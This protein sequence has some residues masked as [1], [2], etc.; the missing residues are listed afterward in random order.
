M[1]VQK[2]CVVRSVLVAAAALAWGVAHAQQGDDHGD[3]RLSSTR[4]TYGVST[5]GN[6]ASA[7]DVDMFRLDLEGRASL[8]MFA[9]GGLDT[10]GVLYDSEGTVLAE[11]DDNGSGMNFRI[12]MTVDGGVY[13][14]SVASMM[15]VGDYKITARIDRGGDA[16]G[17]T[18]GA[19]TVLPL[20]TRATG[21]ID[22]ASDVDAFRIEL[23]ASA[24][25]RISTGG[26]GDTT[27][28]LRDNTDRELVTATMGGANRNFQINRCMD[29]GIYYL[30]VSA[31][32]VAAYNVTAR[33]TARDHACSH[34]DDDDDD[35]DDDHDDDQGDDGHDDGP[36]AFEI[37][38][39]SISAPI[40]Q[41]KCIACHVQGGEGSPA[42]RFVG[43][44]ESGYQ[45]TNFEQF[46]T[47]LSSGH[48]H[49]DN[50]HVTVILNKIRGLD[51]HG[52]GAPVADGSQQYMDMERFLNALADEVAH[53]DDDA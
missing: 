6:I 39:A 19:S 9:T 13:Y 51:N 18:P 24:D 4:L 50:S 12:A 42:L 47:Y 17:N 25:M 44:G 37:Y 27:G 7:S 28:V 23:A 30:L 15:D 34:D 32:A 3:D 21:R 36:S 5:S 2:R 22:P 11:A 40:V 14:L 48:D 43:S 29:A 10:E 49:E 16:H 41:G 26:S 52:G 35:H 1:G 8:V 33:H 38:T 20:D 53:A 45:T 46:E 31:N